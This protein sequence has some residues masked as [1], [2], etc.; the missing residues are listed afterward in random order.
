M[1]LKEIKQYLVLT[2]ANQ[3]EAC[4]KLLHE[5]KCKIESEMAEMQATLD[6]VEY[7][8]GNFIE[9]MNRSQLQGD[10]EYDG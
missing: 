6:I 1:P 7:K 8:L 10:E 9:L 2:A 3:Y 5:H 4:Y